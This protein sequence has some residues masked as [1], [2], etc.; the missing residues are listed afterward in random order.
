[1]GFSHLLRT[2]EDIKS[3][4]IRYNILYDM[5][6]SYCHKGDI[7]DQRLPHIVF[8]PLISILEGGVSFPVAL[9]LLRTLGFYGLSPDQC[10]PNF[11]RVVS[12]EGR[13]NQ[14]YGLN[15]THYDINFLYTIQGSLKHGYYL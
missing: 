13:F 14:M 6:I 15:L 3:F 10:L 8:F 11:Y 4:K 1:M 12:C 7:E 9:L 5:N 2:S